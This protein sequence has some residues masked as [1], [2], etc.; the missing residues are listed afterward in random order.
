MPLHKRG[1]ANTLARGRKISWEHCG[2][3]CAQSGSRISFN[4]M[5]DEV[6]G[7]LPK[8][9]FA[10]SH[11]HNFGEHHVLQP[12]SFPK[13]RHNQRL[14]QSL[15][16]GILEDVIWTLRLVPG[17]VFAYGNTF[18]QGRKLLVGKTLCAQEWLHIATPSFGRGGCGVPA[19][20]LGSSQGLSPK[21]LQP[22]SKSFM[23]PRLAQEDWCQ[24]Q[25]VLGFTSCFFKLSYSNS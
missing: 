3:H 13:S 24:V 14:I 2:K 10:S 18:F 5:R 8:H 12:W 25:Y 21:V 20:V 15:H 16:S 4:T 1:N 6:R 22:V 19:A 11:T 17:S 7:S 23:S 9:P